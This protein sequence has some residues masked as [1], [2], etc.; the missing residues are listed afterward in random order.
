VGAVRGRPAGVFEWTGVLRQGDRPIPRLT[1]AAATWPTPRPD[2]R[3]V[4][5]LRRSTVVVATVTLALA[6]FPPALARRDDPAREI[7]WGPCPVVLPTDRPV[8]CG[9][10][11]VPEVR[12]DPDTRTIRVAF[13]IVR[14]PEPARPD[15]VVFLMGG[16]SYPA[17]DPFSTLFYFD[18]ATYVE[19]RDLVLVDFRGN[20]SSDPFLSCP[21][22]VQLELDAGPDGG[23]DEEFFQANRACRDR[24]SEVADLRHY[25]S[26]DTAQDLRDLRLALGLERWNVMAFS[27]GGEP[28]FQLLRLDP[29]GIRSIVLDSPITNLA[30]PEVVH[31]WW[32]EIPDRQLQLV[33][34][35]CRDQP[36]CDDAFPRL[37]PRFM[38]LVSRLNEAPQTVTIP[39]EGGGSV[40][41]D[42]NGDMLMEEVAFI[43]GDPLAWEFGPAVVD[44][45]VRS[46]IEVLFDF[47]IEPPEPPSEPPPEP[48]V[49]E[50]RT[51]SY[52]CREV[53]AFQTPAMNR[54]SARHFPAWGFAP[55]EV[56]R[57]L[58]H[59]CEAWD[60]GRASPSI[61]RYVTSATPALL[62]S[63][64]WDGAVPNPPIQ[65][66]AAHLRDSTLIEV[67]GIGHGALASYLGWQDCPR[68]IAAA[69]LDH[70]RAEV[71][72]SCVNEMPHV[73]FWVPGHGPGAA[74]VGALLERAPA[75]SA[76]DIPALSFGDHH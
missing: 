74:R 69:F 43:V 23:T 24:L 48:I 60:V 33:F 41:F 22:F 10:L 19:D 73:V 65:A 49:A 62:F 20:Q 18:H 54:I 56:P 9:E 14:A 75:T 32:L 42:V 40:S 70:P 44:E 4:M 34:V 36:A 51:W 46:G 12:G 55:S 28:A 3:A 21:E 37:E 5:D 11:L 6:S 52:R 61:H 59:M 17:I 63:D 30:R 39:V 1:C 2:L 58:R 29:S 53:F 8:D 26:I 13:A 7:D 57:F 15:P 71:D 68:S 72:T 31:W 27:A 76:N 45:V 67:P 16:P 47:T 35:G 66:A 25:G 64:E 38:R 50:G